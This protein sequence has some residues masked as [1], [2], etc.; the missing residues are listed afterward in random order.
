MESLKSGCI[1]IMHTSVPHPASQE[2]LCTSTLL[3]SAGELCGQCCPVAIT[4][5][6]EAPQALKQISHTSKTNEREHIPAVQCS[7]L[8]KQSGEKQLSSII[9]KRDGSPGY[10]NI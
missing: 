2:T 6:C 8:W 10:S 7:Y 3:L 4:K 1:A 9:E 5:T